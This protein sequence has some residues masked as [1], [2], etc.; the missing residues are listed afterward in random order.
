MALR[1]P[2]PAAL[3]RASLPR[4]L[5]EV[6]ARLAGAGHR[7]W[8][9][10]G[11][12]RDLLLHRHRAGPADFD[13]ATP[14]TPEQVMALFPRHVPTGVK[15]GTVTVLVGAEPGKVEVTTFRGESGYADGRRPDAVTFLADIDADLARRDFTVNALAWDPLAPAFRDPFGGLEDLRRRRLRAV[16]EATARFA[17][18]G[19]RPL[20][21]VRLAAQLGF[22]LHPATRAAIP[23]A[24][25]VVVRVSAERICDELTKLLGSPR[26]AH[27]LALCAA[28]GLLDAVFPE[29]ARLPPVL[30]RHALAAAGAARGPLPVQ[31]AALLHAAAAGEPPAAVARE[32]REAL[33]RL[34]F[35]GAV[36][37][38]AEQLI[39]EHGCLRARGR[40]PVPASDPEVR[41]LLSRVGAGRAPALLALREADRLALPAAAAR[42]E[43]APGRALAR[44]VRRVLAARPPLGTGDLALDGQ[45][46]M[47]LLGIGPGREVG[48]ALRHLLDLALE[49]PSLNTRGGLAAALRGWWGSRSR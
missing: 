32:A 22:G 14:A 34:R 18:D 6:L 33:G 36:A 40:V 24:L 29:L 41:R 7:S 47:A 4:A 23:A 13:L 16:G 37:D 49:D 46:A 26:P 30:R 44:R 43:R 5:T 48:E 39:R 10:G 35:P 38:E 25:P 8:V 15:H 45:E 17:E 20:R 31:L 28:T 9:V 3:A 1:R 19:L 12:V 2:I 21:A 11:A 42:R 27:G